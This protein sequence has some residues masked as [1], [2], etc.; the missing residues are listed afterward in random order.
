MALDADGFVAEPDPLWAAR[1]RAMQILNCGLCDDDGYH[2]STVCDHVD[3]T[4]T[5][6]QGMDKVRAAMGWT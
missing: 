5:A 6:K 3:R 4:E 1:Q 2:G